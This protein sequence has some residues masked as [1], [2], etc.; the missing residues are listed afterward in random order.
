M[1]RRNYTLFVLCS[2]LLMGCKD[3]VGPSSSSQ[4]GQSENVPT[5]SSK[6]SEST[7]SIFSKPSDSGGKEESSKPSA[8]VDL[9]ANWPTEIKEF[10]K[11][12]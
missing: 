9:Y 2:L 1:K 3:K 8:S 12:I 7:P 4:S 10:L 5:E 11:E 6:P